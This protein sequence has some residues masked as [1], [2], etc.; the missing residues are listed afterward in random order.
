MRAETRHQLKTDKFTRVTIGAA[1]ATAHWSIEH[2]SK[3]ITGVATLVVAIAALAATW[4]YLSHQDDKANME[5]TQAVRTLETQIRPAGTPETP[6]FPSFASLQERGAAARRQLQ[7]VIDKYPHTHSA[8]IA[9]YLMGTTA[10]DLGDNATAE[11]ELRDVASR[12][13]RD[14]AALAKLG[15]AS[16]YGSTNRT[17][18]ALDLYKQLID[19]PTA[20]VSKVTAQI[21]LASLYE[22][23]QQPQ[24]AKKIYE[25]VVKENPR[26]EAESIAQSKLQA[27]K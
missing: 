12:H 7:A 10:L 22:A 19:K 3:I 18:D 11:R 24:E 14:L 9:R 20:T 1:E 2:K 16:L 25:Q 4:L 27:L 5:L 8:D 15:L 21:Q 13:N 26:T 23:S 17:R 6:N